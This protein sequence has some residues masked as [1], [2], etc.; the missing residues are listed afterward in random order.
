M[1][2]ISLSPKSILFIILGIIII[3]LELIS[4]YLDIG[5]IV[6]DP[7]GNI[8]QTEQ[9]ITDEYGYEQKIILIAEFTDNGLLNI[10]SADKLFTPIEKRSFEYKLHVWEN[11]GNIYFKTDSLLSFTIFKENATPATMLMECI[12]SRVL[13]SS[14]YDEDKSFVTYENTDDIGSQLELEIKFYKNSI[15]LDG[16]KLTKI[17]EINPVSAELIRLFID[18]NEFFYEYMK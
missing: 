2:K 1:K 16:I 6:Y 18:N 4:F 7:R 9:V 17:N 5:S 11:I 15:V 13:S 14:A 3:P 12:Q 10:I 8:Y